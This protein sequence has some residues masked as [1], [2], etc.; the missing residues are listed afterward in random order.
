MNTISKQRG[1]TL[2]ETVIYIALFSILI[3]SV[4]VSTY[5]LF[6]SENKNTSYALLIYEGEFLL[7]KIAFT[8]S[9]T[10]TIHAPHENATSTSLSITPADVMN[11]NPIVF[12]QIGKDLKIFR[13]TNQGQ[14][15]NNPDVS[16]TNVIFSHIHATTSP[17]V[18][19]SIYI[20]FTLQ[21]LTNGG[22][23][24]SEKFNTVQYIRR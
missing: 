13:G 15:L 5:T 6:E 20:E 4:I 18:S 7:Q 22:K 17:A 21:T 9:S 16:V 14:I 8:L 19:D 23:Q 3:G 2:I 24:I 10:D 12:A 1:V 11:G